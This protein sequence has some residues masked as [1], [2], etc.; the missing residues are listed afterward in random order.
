MR[1]LIAIA[2]PLLALLSLLP[3]GRAAAQAE[4][5]GFPETGFCISGPIRA[6][7]E[8]NGGLPIFGYPIGPLQQESIYNDDN[9]VA[10]TGPTQWF[11]RDRLEDHS[12]EGIGVLAGRLGAEQLN[13]LTRDLVVPR[14]ER[15]P[16]QAPGCRFFP[17]TGFNVCGQFRQYWEQNGGLERF[18]YPLSRPFE[19][20]MGAWSG[21]V[22]YF[23][24][25]RM[26]QHSIYPPGVDVVML[27]LLGR[28]VRDRVPSAPC[29]NDVPVELRASLRAAVFANQMGCPTEVRPDVPLA[30][31]SF[32]RGNML[33][34]AGAD[35]GIFVVRTI[36]LPLAYSRH[37]DTF[38]E[39][40][41]ERANLTP[42][43][44]LSEPARGFGKV[45]REQPGVRD[46]LGWATAPERGDRGVF[47]P[48]TSGGAVVW[49][50]G[51]D[52]VYIFGPGT[53]VTVFERYRY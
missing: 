44:G 35:P 12:N 10:W 1:R 21:T 49:L 20:T 25:R 41:P 5:R 47:I 42:P 8:R 50:Q 26:E 15:E 27:G 48:F 39:G 30:E 38:R 6:Y 9:T 3:A 2:L 34:V 11:E 36:P 43:P 45:W 28:E 24:R 29:P 4:E 32:E 22:Q 51:S 52:F 7:W 19:L 18:G 17:E 33:W 46:A 40:E 23:E 31:Q 14:P 16:G 13:A 53:Q 37:F